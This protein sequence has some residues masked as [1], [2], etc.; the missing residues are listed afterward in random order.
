MEN[1]LSYIFVGAFIFVLLIGGV[2]SILWLGNYSDK[3]NYKF[4]H[5]STKESVSG[6]NDKAPVKFKGVQIGE[7]RSVAINPKNAEEVLVTIRVQDSAPI[8]EDTYAVLEA[9]GITGLSFIQLAGGTNDA[10]ELKT[11]AKPEEYGYIPSQPSTFSRLDR[12][13]TSLSQKAETIFERTNELMNDKNLKNIETIIENSAKIT[14]L[15]KN[16]LANIESHNKEIHQLLQEGIR[17][18]KAAIE[19]S[20]SVKNA[21]NSFSDAINNTGIDTMN[22][23]RDASQSVKKVMGELNTKVDAGAFDINIMVK[24]NLA[25]LQNSLNELQVLMN[26][27]RGLVTNLKDSP[28][29]LL[30][31]SETISPAPHEH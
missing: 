24:E 2:A 10:K 3:G 1:R 19:A 7:V 11:G 16:T 6:L 27:T 13:I 12:T 8:K 21:S 17:L 18:E 15:T 9:Q 25:P 20:N 30:F 28:S 23:V 22:N 31:K 29:D 26:E 14:E 5:I 4:Y